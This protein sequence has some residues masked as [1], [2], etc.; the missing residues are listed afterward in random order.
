MAIRM[1]GK[2]VLAPTQ[3]DHSLSKDPEK[4]ATDTAEPNDLLVTFSESDPGNPKDWNKSRKWTVT[5]V[6]SATGFTRIMI[7]TMMAPAL[8]TIAAEFNLN[9]VEANM[10]LSVYLLAT[11]F[12]PLVCLIKWI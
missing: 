7:S 1:P 2:D 12:G 5:A 4:A 6:L 9:S 3:N 8:G 10:A 11:A